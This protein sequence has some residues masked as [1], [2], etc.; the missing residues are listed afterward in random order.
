MSAQPNACPV[1]GETRKMSSIR[2]R[3]QPLVDGFVDPCENATQLAIER[4]KRIAHLE[5]A[6]TRIKN[7]ADAPDPD[8]CGDLRQG[9]HC[10][11]EDRNINDC[12]DACDYGYSEGVSRTMYWAVNEAENALKENPK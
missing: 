6:L 2:F 10:G 9:L 7:L 5:A 1:C 11:L 4:A 12:Y 3:C 8:P